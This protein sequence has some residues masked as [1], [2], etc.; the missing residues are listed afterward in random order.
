MLSRLMGFSLVKSSSP[1]V[2]RRLYLFISMCVSMYMMDLFVC[3]CGLI[4]MIIS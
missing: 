1:E 2:T 3:G 4:M